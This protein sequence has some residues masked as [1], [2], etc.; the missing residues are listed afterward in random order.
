M[1]AHNFT[2]SDLE[3][4]ESSIAFRKYGGRKLQGG[5][6]GGVEN[7][8]GYSGTPRNY[9]STILPT[10]QHRHSGCTNCIFNKVLHL[11][12]PQAPSVPFTPK[13]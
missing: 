5:K 9:Y 8:F 2:P 6:W 12:I 13:G 1:I 11:R 10:A 7:T 4:A 3:L